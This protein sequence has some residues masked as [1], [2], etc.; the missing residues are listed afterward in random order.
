[1]RKNFSHGA[2]HQERASFSCLADLRC[3]RVVV[4][5][6]EHFVLINVY[7]PNAGERPERARLGFKLKFLS[8]LEAK[9]YSLVSQGR[10]VSWH[11]SVL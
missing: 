11:N 6:L 4:T 3:S 5:D 10:E 1:M 8:E 7:V 2:A 9:V